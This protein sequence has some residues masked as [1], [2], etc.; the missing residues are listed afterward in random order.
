MSKQLFNLVVRKTVESRLFPIVGSLGLWELHKNHPSWPYDPC[1][2]LGVKIPN[3]NRKVLENADLKEKF[4][5]TSWDVADVAFGT[6]ASGAA[7]RKRSTI[8]TT[9]EVSPGRK[10]RS[11][12]IWKRWSPGP[13]SKVL[14][15]ENFF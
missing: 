11:N 14:I 6:N 9:T 15:L 7:F 3:F 1:D 4:N 2:L 13:I 5:R 10:I 12:G 8:S